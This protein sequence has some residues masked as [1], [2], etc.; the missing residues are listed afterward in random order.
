MKGG[1]SSLSSPVELGSAFAWPP[2]ASRV[3]VGLVI[4]SSNLSIYPDARLKTRLAG[5]FA[6]VASVF[7]VS[8]LAIFRDPDA[9]ESDHRLF[10]KVVRYMLLP[11]YLRVRVWRLDPELRYAGLLPPLNIYPH[12]PE[13]RTPGVGDIRY[14]LVLDER[15]A[16]EVGWAK[17]C[18]LIEPLPA[19]VGSVDLFEVVSLE[20]FLCRRAPRDGIYVGY[21]VV[22]LGSTE[23]LAK[24]LGEF[25]LVIN[26]SKRGAAL[27]SV[28]SDPDSA[29]R[30]TKARSVCL[31]FGNP[32]KD[33]DE[34]IGGGL[35]VDLT[36][37]FIPYQGV[38]SVRT[39]EAVTA[40][41]AV[42]NLLLT[43]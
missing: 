31:L 19:K 34:I 1:S 37:N 35:R 13:G 10:V 26:T 14:G 40:S 17:P 9:E 38:L 20:P 18:R 15:G 33:L 36:V 6:R 22:E 11:P 43:N 27:A 2:P 32:R 28:L 25:Q 29:R 4:P 7:R 41:L 5:E 30:L 24:Y 8:S 21:E 12:N 23:D 39:L 3:R 42:L 16:V